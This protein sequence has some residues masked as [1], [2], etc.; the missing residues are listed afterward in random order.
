MRGRGVPPGNGRGFVR[1][2]DDGGVTKQEWEALIGEFIA[3]AMS[4]PD[5]ERRFLDGH[6][7]T[8][9][10][11]ESVP[12]AVDLLFYE[13]DAYCQDPALRGPNDLDEAGLRDAARLLL[14]RIDEPW[15]PLPGQPTKDQN[16]ANFRRAAA[17]LGLL[18]K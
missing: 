17:R 9:E 18:R 7:Q 15:P 3:G 10:L 2:G 13:V 6:R 14:P 8:V 4:G 1:T 11:G 16:D 5:F 12:Y